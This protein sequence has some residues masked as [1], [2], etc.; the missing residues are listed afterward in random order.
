M[1]LIWETIENSLF[2]RKGI[3]FGHKR[4]SIKNSLMDIYFFSSG[5]VVAMY[6][7]NHGLS[8]FLISTFFFFK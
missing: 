8:F 5:G 2:Y 4:D 1:S 6:N 3:K 7:I